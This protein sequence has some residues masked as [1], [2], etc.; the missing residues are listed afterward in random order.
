MTSNV[1]ELNSGSGSVV[2]RGIEVP[3]D[4]D[5]GHEFTVDCTRYVENLI[6]ET[7]V[8]KKYDLDEDTW[9]S[10][11][12]HNVLQRAVGR[13]K[14]RRIHNGDAAREKAAHLLVE[15]VGVVGDIARDAGSPPRARIEASREL[16]QVAAAGADDAPAAEK[17][18]FHISI[19]FGTAK[20]VKEIELTPKPQIIEHD[21]DEHEG[22]YDG[23]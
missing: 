2:L 4:S 14:E 16:R 6:T 13:E 8:K 19:N 23:I 11:A 17:E 10:L 12:S 1:T 3:V 18:R 21:V 22:D 20:I 9:Q 7:Q 5:V 15:A